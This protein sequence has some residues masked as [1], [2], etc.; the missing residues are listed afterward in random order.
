MKL[1]EMAL[2]IEKHIEDETKG[3]PMLTIEQKR[4]ILMVVMKE[5]RGSE[6][7]KEVEKYINDCYWRMYG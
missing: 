4:K 2:L 7:P 5:S 3:G 6:N 1:S